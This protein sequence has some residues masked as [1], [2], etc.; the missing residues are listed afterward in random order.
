ME[1]IMYYELDSR[2]LSG[3]EKNLQSFKITWETDLEKGTGFNYV[4]SEGFEVA[5]VFIVD[6]PRMMRIENKYKMKKEIDGH[7]I[8]LTFDFDES[9]TDHDG[10]TIERQI[11][12]EVVVKLKVI[13]ADIERF[14]VLVDTY[15]VIAA[16]IF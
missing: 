4:E 6:V 16:E 13:D 3:I 14:I 5:P 2:T 10:E 12:I 15:D 7:E 11:H 1:N 9:Y 8:D